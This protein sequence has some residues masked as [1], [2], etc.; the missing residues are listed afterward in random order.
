MICLTLYLPILH[1]SSYKGKGHFEVSFHQTE[2]WRGIHVCQERWEYIQFDHCRASHFYSDGTTA[3]DASGMD[4][5]WEFVVIVCL[6][7]C[8]YRWRAD[9]WQTPERL[10]SEVPE[11]SHT[12]LQLLSASL[13]SW[14]SPNNIYVLV[15]YGI[16]HWVFVY[17][18]VL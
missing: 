11:K 6:F 8:S 15:Q 18:L 13:G 5:S 9:K 17:F 12:H 4:L 1:I 14:K 7:V 2:S 16:F 3:V 10:S